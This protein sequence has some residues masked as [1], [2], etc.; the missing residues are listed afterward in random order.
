M[1]QVKECAPGI[2][3]SCKHWRCVCR[4][5]LSLGFAVAFGGNSVQYVLSASSGLVK[6][7]RVDQSS[8]EV[9]GA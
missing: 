8:I 4:L 5:E 9:C 7:G 2:L 6:V 3:L 1:G